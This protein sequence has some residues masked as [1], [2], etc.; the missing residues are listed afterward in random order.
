M[1]DTKSKLLDAA[2]HLTQTRG[3]N[4]FSYLDLADE[5]GIKTSSIHYHFKTKAD[6]ASAMV[7]RIHEVHGESFDAIDRDVK[8]PEKRLLAVVEVFQAYVRDEKFCLCGMLSV[9]LESVSSEVRTQLQK[10]FDAFRAWLA[11]QFKEM[12]RRDAKQRALEFLSTLEGSLLIAR[13]E[14]D[15]KIIRQ[16]MK[17]F[18]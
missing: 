8:T 1:A 3:F 17:G 2:E 15:P 13:V 14:G 10:Y 12:E 5:I 6:L 11:K 16:A 7:E 9:E 18:L 4:G